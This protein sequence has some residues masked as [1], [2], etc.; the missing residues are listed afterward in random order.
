MKTLILAA[1]LAALALFGRAVS[2]V[3]PPSEIKPCKQAA[4]RP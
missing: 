3:K 4:T 2:E 1:T